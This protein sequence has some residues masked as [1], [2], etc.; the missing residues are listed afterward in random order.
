V[1]I[2]A[3]NIA[4]WHFDEMARRFVATV[5]F[6]AN[7]VVSGDTSL[8]REAW[9]IERSS[10]AR[11][12]P[13]PGVR[14]FGC[15][16]CGA[17]L[18]R[19]SEQLCAACGQEVPAGRFDWLVTKIARRLSERTGTSL[20]G[21]VPEQGTG[22]PTIVHPGLE[23]EKAALLA[24]DPAALTGLEAR[25]RLIFTELNAAWATQDLRGARPYLSS[26]LFAT[27]QQQVK[28][29]VSQGLV[30]VVDGAHITRWEMAKLARDPRYDALTVRLFGSGRDYTYR[31]TTRELVGGDDEADRPYSEYWTLIRGSNVRGAP[32]VDKRCPQC[33]GPLAVGMEGNCEHCGALVASGEFDWILS[34]IE[35][36]D[37]YRG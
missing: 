23:A 27:L 12:R 4:K 22:T 18:E 21:T 32:R 34:G 36:D 20:T 35:Q 3:M 14:A 28:A 31:K 10:R 8:V 16:S 2:G 25:L 17:P 19:V 26:S 37:A 9:T 15:P 6:E 30:N 24:D 11:T 5:D 7:L 33:A 29:Y 1:I 13:W